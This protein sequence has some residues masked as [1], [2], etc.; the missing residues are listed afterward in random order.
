MSRLWRLA[1]EV[2]REYRDFGVKEV[3]QIEA[4]AKK[5]E[6]ARVQLRKVRHRVLTD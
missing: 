6:Q 2:W 4:Q 1:R 3:K 5:I